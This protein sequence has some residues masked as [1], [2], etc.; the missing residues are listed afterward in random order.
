LKAKTEKNYRNWSIR[1]YCCVFF[2][3]QI[4]SSYSSK[5]LLHWHWHLGFYIQSL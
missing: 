3:G 2:V 5:R 4:D 1:W